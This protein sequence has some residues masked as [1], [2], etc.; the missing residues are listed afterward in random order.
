MIKKKISLRLH[1]FL[2]FLVVFL[3]SFAVIIFSFTI[4]VANYIQNDSND[5]LK[6]TEDKARILAA[7]KVD[8]RPAL[9]GQTDNSDK[10]KERI[11]E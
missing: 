7:Q 1:I 10:I 3:I 2:S 4:V 9:T 11:I 6:I 8:D 5:K